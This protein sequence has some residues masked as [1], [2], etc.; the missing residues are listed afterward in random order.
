MDLL[1]AQR[2]MR[3]QT[4]TQVG[5]VAIWVPRRSHA[6]VDLAHLHAGPGHLFIGQCAEHFPWSMPPAEGH[7]EATPRGDG[8]AG[9]LGRE[10]GGRPRD[11]IGIDQRLDLHGTLTVGFCQ[12]PG[13]TT[14]ESTS[15]G[16]HVPASYSWTG[17]PAFRTG[18]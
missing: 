17:G 16:P 5:E 10:R 3:E 9:R 15:F 14:L 11:R 6:L 7:H 13:G 8:R 12:P 18:S 2:T 1:G 4:F